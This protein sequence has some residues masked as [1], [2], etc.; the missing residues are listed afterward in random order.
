MKNCHAACTAL[1]FCTPYQ[2][3]A[4]LL[5]PRFQ[6]SPDHLCSGIV[7]P[8]VHLSN[9]KGPFDVVKQQSPFPPAH[10]TEGQSST[11]KLTRNH[12]MP[13]AYL[14]LTNS[15]HHNNSDTSHY[16]SDNILLHHL[17]P[18]RPPSKKSSLRPFHLKLGGYSSLIGQSYEVKTP[19]NHIFQ[20]GRPIIRA[21]A[22]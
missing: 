8:L 16:S 6:E 17:R 7:Q 22:A 9:S 19:P 18:N 3:S 20:Q 15:R 21:T 1:A 10:A 4:T 5:C 12:F 14:P 2:V 11:Y 13:Q